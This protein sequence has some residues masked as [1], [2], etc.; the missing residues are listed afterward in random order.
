MKPGWFDR[1]TEDA[2][3]RVRRDS[4]VKLAVLV[5][6]AERPELAGHGDRPA[7]RSSLEGGR[8]GLTFPYWKVGESSGPLRTGAEPSWVFHC[9]SGSR[10]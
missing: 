9:P 7:R 8:S 3:A 1:L 5:A 2:V 10:I 4:Q 6:K